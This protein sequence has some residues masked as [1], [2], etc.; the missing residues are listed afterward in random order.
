[1]R[2]MR[3]ID[4]LRRVL[5]VILGTVV[6][7]LFVIGVIA[8]SNLV[9]DS[10]SWVAYAI[11]PIGAFGIIVALLPLIT[12]VH[13]LW[14]AG[15]ASGRAERDSRRDAESARAELSMNKI[16]PRGPDRHT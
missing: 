13:N 7:T 11:V 14:V 12:V 10:I 6:V 16:R 15:S 1:M 4:L 5:S 8:F 2:S 3:T 9:T